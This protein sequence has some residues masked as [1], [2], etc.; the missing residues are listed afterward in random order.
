MVLEKIFNKKITYLIYFI[1]LF[2]VAGP[3]IP[4][5]I[6]S[7]L[8]ILFVIYCFIKKEFGLFKNKIIFFYSIF[9]IIIILSSLNSDLKIISL[10]QSLF[11]VRFLIFAVFL[12]LLIKNDRNFFKNFFPIILFTL[13]LVV[14]DGY[15]QFFFD[16]NLFGFERPYANQ[17]L[18]GF[19][20]DEWILGS[21]LV[22]ILPIFLCI[23][24]L[25]PY[26]NNKLILIFV[27]LY[28]LLIF[29]S[30]ER[31]SFFLLLIFIS[32]ILIFF[33]M[34]KIYKFSLI[35]I[36]IL[37]PLIVISIDENMKERMF[38]QV[39]I[40]LGIFE[41]I[42]PNANSSRQIKCC[43]I[44]KYLFS[45][46]HSKHYEVGVRMFLDKPFLGHGLKSFRYKCHEF[47]EDIGCGSH[48][49][50]TY[51]Q[52]LAE[53]GVFSFLM[54]FILFLYFCNLLIKNYLNRKNIDNNIYNARVC[55][56]ASFVMNLFPLIPTGS[57]FTNWLSII[58]FFPLG[59]L[60][61]LYNYP[62]YGKKN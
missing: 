54:I 59:M 60:F 10:K 20:N 21:Y 52:L 28:G 45:L 18:S 27:T 22:R 46:G 42:P 50:N 38:N 11:H 15:Y 35:S 57:F 55:I 6:I 14:F 19:F 24:I 1:P 58:Y 53:S 49:H 13:I 17:R 4:D 7:F 25:S 8:S 48:P 56:I 5:L 47:Q 16:V 51:V 40:S 33:N 44:P 39:L 29:L 37:V 26:R 3:A 12:Y 31:S 30:G 41:D 34:R 43:K 32:L 36:I 9:W 23:V 62:Q 61:Y 2:M